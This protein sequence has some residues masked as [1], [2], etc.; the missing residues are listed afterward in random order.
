MNREDIQKIGDQYAQIC[1][2][3]ILQQRFERRERRR[4]LIL[5]MATILL[6]I[7][8]LVFVLINLS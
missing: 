2:E 5:L 4:R 6:I 7:I 1:Q 8:C 3:H